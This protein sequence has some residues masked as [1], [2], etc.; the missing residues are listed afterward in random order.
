M[1]AY[2]KILAGVA[3][4]SL[5]VPAYAAQPAETEMGLS[6][7]IVTA[8][9][10]SESLQDVAIS[11]TAADADALA[12]AR[13]ENIANVQA[14]SPS[15]NFRS[16][17]ISTSTA[18]VIIRGLGTTGNSRSFEGSVGVFIDGVYRTRAAAALN[19]F[20]D[21][22]NLQILR[23]PQGTLFGKN[24][25]A[26]ALL[27]TSTQPDIYEPGGMVDLG[28]GNY[29]SL[30]VRG[31]VNVPI[32]DQ[33]AVRVAGL[34]SHNDGFFRDATTRNRVNDDSTRAIKGQLLWE[35][36]DGVSI[37]L[38]GDYLQSE[39]NCCYYVSDFIDGV[40]QPLIDGLTQAW[41]GVVPPRDG[42]LHFEQ[43]LNGDGRQLTRDYGGTALMDFDIG[44]GTLRSVTAYRKFTVDQ[45][46]MDPEFSG[47]DVL[48]YHEDFGSRFISQ[49]LTYTARIEP[50]NGDLVL[51]AF[52]ADEK[53]NASR[54][55]PNAFQGQ[56]YWDTLLG[57]GVANAPVQISPDGTIIDPDTTHELMWGT[58]KSYAAFA[59]LESHVTDQI[60]LIGG[61]RYSVEKKT[62]GFH[63]GAFSSDPKVWG[64]VM[65]AAPAPAYEDATTDK[66]V[67]GTV[68]IQY[69][70]VDN[71]MLYATFN[72]GFKAGG[73]MMD[74]NAAGG[75][76]N[77]PD[78]TPGG[79]PL[80]PRY[81]PEKVN[82]FELGAKMQYLDN[83]AR[84]NIALYYYDIS[85]IQVAQFVG[86]TYTVL[87]A[88][89]AKNYGAEIENTFRLTPGLMLKLDATWVPH[90][91]F[92]EDPLLDP[93]LSGHRFRTAS[94]LQGN[95]SLSLD[96]PVNDVMNV[97]GR[98]QYQYASK[99]YINTATTSVR[100][101]ISLVDAN[102]G[103]RFPDAGVNVEAWVQN[104]TDKRYV[105]ATTKTALQV[106]DEN[107]FLGAPRTFG[108]RLRAHF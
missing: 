9:R 32:A 33:A 19:T 92:G 60:S 95:A 27:L 69:R 57:P 55:V 101:A 25:T 7:I 63:Y 54:K 3:M 83:R 68:G 90:A 73:V 13:V 5:A 93:V 61:I 99:Q 40:T 11:I 45:R 28:Y 24:T 2:H 80:D 76:A 43:T 70:P 16:A 36:S 50:L 47:A 86:I 65:G 103:V 77:N 97:T 75:V 48:R 107:A 100:P 84:T 78:I 20:L 15:I 59:H 87:N 108:V 12:E 14:I 26:G 35:P 29:N 37:R 58:A 89:S 67:S 56:A 91:K 39:G 31:A 105:V 49:E 94:K 44:P 17:H 10:R 104:L 106:G 96:Q 1:S 52:F 41:G 82:A 6:D 38:I 79:E 42:K 18:N 74:A 98:V 88:K 53:L 102:L 72:H 23:G 46:D 64:L 71:V 51:G 62:G 81:K 66:A 85:N 30:L 4:I 21:I 34:V 22:D 8:Q